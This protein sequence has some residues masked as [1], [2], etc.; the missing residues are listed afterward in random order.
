MENDTPPSRA[1]RV[2]AV[3]SAGRHF[4]QLMQIRAGLA[5]TFGAP[6]AHVVPD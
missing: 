1:M 6:P 5:E 4:E 2:F 3:A